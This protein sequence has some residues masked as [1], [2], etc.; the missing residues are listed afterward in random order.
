MHDLC[1]L[2]HNTNKKANS[3]VQKPVQVNLKF[4]YIAKVVPYIELH[5]FMK[6]H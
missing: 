4:I 1:D 3:L 5:W 6:L 2:I